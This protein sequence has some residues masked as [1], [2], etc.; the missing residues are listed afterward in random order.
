[1][2]FRISADQDW[3]RLGQIDPYF[4][5]LSNDKYKSANIDSEAKLDFFAS[6]VSHVNKS[7]RSSKKF[8]RL[9]SN[10]NGS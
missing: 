6:G 2:V 9:C 7:A 4:A 5:V 10:W 8:V 3:K 1:M